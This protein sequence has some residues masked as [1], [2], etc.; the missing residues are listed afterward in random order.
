M[1]HELGHIEKY[2]ITKRK[3]SI[4]NLKDIDN[5]TNLSLIAGS[6]IANNSEYLMQSIIT[7]KVGISNYYKSFSRDQERE[8]DY[9]AVETLNKLRLS[10]DPL[11][12][13]LSFL[14]NNQYKKD[15]IQITKYFPL[16]Q[17][18]KKGL[19]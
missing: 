19:Q 9:Y 11:I 5:I 1:A 18:M 15:M 10:A 7:N 6:L 14:E 2:H 8:A 17:Y 4:K 13:F 3:K 12:E 16:T